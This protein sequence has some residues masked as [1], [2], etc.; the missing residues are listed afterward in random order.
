MAQGQSP[1]R[2]VAL[3]TGGTQGIGLECAKILAAEGYDL[4]LVGRDKEKAERACALI[5]KN[6][7]V[8]ATPLPQDLKEIDAPQKIFDAVHAMGVHV[9][10]LINNAGFGI[11]G[12][13]ATTQL[14]YEIGMM[15]LNMETVVRLTK[16]FL[17]DMIARR[18]GKILN[19]AS[20]AAFQAGPYMSIYCATKAFV[21]S[22]SE[23]LA[24]EQRGKNI[25]VTALCPGPTKT[26]FQANAHLEELAPKQGSAADP[27]VVA[28]AGIHGLMS[29]RA[30]VVP[31]FKNTFLIFMER[32][33]P[34][35]SVVRA[36]AK[37][38]KKMA[39]KES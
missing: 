9:S 23:A 17:P 25:T 27:F 33:L 15:R 31:G 3:V 35:R 22:F 26:G 7:S 4:I 21:L 19:V 28:S 18:S 5:Q 10:L 13:F 20:T 14:D 29:G 39:Q 16:L 32:F 8:S 37:V 38:L 24:E 12:D 36:A 2:E 30:V 1:E 11:Q 6:F 34:R